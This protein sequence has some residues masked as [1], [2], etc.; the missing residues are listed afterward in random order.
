MN[1]LRE[2][3]GVYERDLILEGSYDVGIRYFS[4]LDEDVT[5][6]RSVHRKFM[7][8]VDTWDE[9]GEPEVV[10]ITIEPGDRLNEVSDDA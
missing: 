1:A 4:Q 3:T 6:F 9:L 10:T 7:L 2:T 8:D 5:E